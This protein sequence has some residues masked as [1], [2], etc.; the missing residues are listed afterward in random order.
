[1]TRNRRARRIPSRKLVATS[2]VLLVGGLT[3]L[4]SG[5]GPGAERTGEEGRAGGPREAAPLGPLAPWPHGVSRPRAVLR[6]PIEP[7]QQTALEFGER[8]HWLQPWRAYLDTVPG[9]RLRHGLGVNFNVAPSDAAA[10]ARLL[11]AAGI[12][13]ARVEL[14]WGDFDFAHPTRLRNPE[15]VRLVFGALARHGIRPLVLLNANHTAPCPTRFFQAR[16]VERAQKGDRTVRLDRRTAEA[17]VPGRTGLNRT[18]DGKAADVLFTSVN[19]D[20]VA[21]LSKPLPHNLSAGEHPAA[22][23]RYAPFEAPR[24]ADGRRNQ[25]FEAT[26]EGWLSYVEAATAKVRAYLRSTDFD[27]EIWNELSFG[28]EFLDARTYYQPAEQGRGNVPEAVLDTTV[29]F[30]R[31]PERGLSGVGIVN[32]FASERP[33]DSGATSPP[34]LT[35]IAKHPY[36]E[37]RRFPQ[38]AE[39]SGVMPLDATGRADGV[40]VGEGRW[41]DRFTPRYTAMF[42]EYFLTAIQTEHLIRDLSP[43]TTEVYGTPHGRRTSPRASPPPSIWVTE[44]NTDPA[45]VRTPNPSGPLA[46]ADRRLQAKAVLRGYLAFLNKGVGA[47]YVFAAAGDR[48]GIVRPSFF[49]TLRRTRRYPGDRAG[50]STVGAIRRLSRYF[51]SASPLKQTMTLRLL[52][53]GDYELREQWAGDGT[54]RHPPLRDRDVVAFLPFQLDDRRILVATYVMSRNVASSLPAERFA[55]AIGGLR[56]CPATIR[57]SDPLSG[58]RVPVQKVSCSARRLVVSLP[59]TDSPRFLH[60]KLPPRRTATHRGEG[61]ATLRRD[62][63]KGDPS[64]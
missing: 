38:S 56:R 7:R 59:L 4:I 47:F 58:E 64:Q 42:P 9:T 1:M 29:A 49:A 15:H 30:L 41:R 11:A 10:T 55:F 24:T 60:I 45:T 53:I 28:S 8:S 17:V 31:E 46:P 43:F 37:V 32:G 23:L 36:A 62:A 14:S 16:I 39:V 54:R 2:T 51:T 6:E 3:W 19:G 12:R 20:G 21:S 44:W 35:A 34:G 61:G 40:S 57:G 48:L 25:A 27:V 18:D 5:Q 33:W 22:T 50:G 13:R 52:A 63:R 26:L